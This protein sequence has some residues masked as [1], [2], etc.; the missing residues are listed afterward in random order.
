MMSNLYENQLISSGPLDLSGVGWGFKYII[1]QKGQNCIHIVM[2][3][4]LY[5]TTTTP[6]H[7]NRKHPRNPPSLKIWIDQPI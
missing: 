2:K 3:F 4:C 5:T 6:L 1:H 7:G